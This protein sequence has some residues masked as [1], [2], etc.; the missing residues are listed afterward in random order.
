[1]LANKLATTTAIAMCQA[2]CHLNPH[3]KVHVPVVE[4]AVHTKMKE[5]HAKNLLHA[6][7]Q[8]HAKK[9]GDKFSWFS[10]RSFQKSLKEEVEGKINTLTVQPFFGN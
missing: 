6:K 7:N 3:G 5:I 2:M 1:M 10:C 9:S 4:G 8:I